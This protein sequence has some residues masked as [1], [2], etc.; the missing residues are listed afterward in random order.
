MDDEQPIPSEQTA[1]YRLASRLPFA[2]APAR[3]FAQSPIRL[4]ADTGAGLT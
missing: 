3:R 4:F 1:L 2:V